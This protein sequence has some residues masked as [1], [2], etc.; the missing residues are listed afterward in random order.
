MTI[1]YEWTAQQG[2]ALECA[3]RIDGNDNVVITVHWRLNGSDGPYSGTTCGAQAIPYTP[4]GDF[5]PYA[6]LTI[7]Q[8]MGWVHAA[9]GPAAVAEAEQRVAD[10]I[11]V[12]ANPPTVTPLPP[13][14]EPAPE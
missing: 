3:P 6:A 12:Q 9:M 7:E 1:S 10:Q 14:A 4:G 5:T 8:V 2:N 13:W 11:A